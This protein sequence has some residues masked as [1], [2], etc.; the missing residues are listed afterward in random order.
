MRRLYIGMIILLGSVFVVAQEN[1]MGFFVT[2]T[3]LG[4][5]GDLGEVSGADAHCQA[6]AETVGAG[7]IQQVVA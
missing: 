2:S 6:L 3:G 4:N 1:P 7:D 5:G